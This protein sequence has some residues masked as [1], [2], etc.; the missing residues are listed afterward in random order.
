M[1]G[2]GEKGPYLAAFQGLRGDLGLRLREHLGR[3]SRFASTLLR[4]KGKTPDQGMYSIE[5]QSCFEHFPATRS[6]PTLGTG[7]MGCG[8]GLESLRFSGSRP[9][10]FPGRRIRK[11]CPLCPLERK[12]PGGR[13]AKNPRASSSSF[14]RN[15]EPVPSS[16]VRPCAN[17]SGFLCCASALS[18]GFEKHLGNDNAGTSTGLGVWRMPPV[19][20]KSCA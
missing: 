3:E 10:L 7:C 20:S 14:H 6:S 15:H 5:R 2:K 11:T 19:D 12:S 9:F 4:I 13:A 1:E 8:E 18:R 16:D 17:V